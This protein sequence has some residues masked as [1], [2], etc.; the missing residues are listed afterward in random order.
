MTRPPLDPV[1]DLVFLCD[2]LPPEFGAVGQYCLLRARELAAAG[3]SVALYGLSSSQD[4]V[5]EE[6]SGA[7]RIVRLKAPLYDRGSLRQRAWWTLRTGCALLWRARRDIRACSEVMFTG[8]PPFLLHLLAPLNVVLRRTLVYRITD[9]FPEVLVA[10]RGGASWGLRLLQRL[11]LFWRRRVQR[12]EVLGED[13]RKRLLDGGVVPER[14]VLKRDCSPVEIGP[15]TPPLTPPAALGGYKVLLYS[16]NFGVAHDYETFLR[17]Y[18]EHHRRG[19]AALALWLNARGRAADRLEQALGE[20]RVPYCRTQ[21]QPLEHLASLLVTPAAHLITLRTEFW[22]YVLPSK[23]YGCI[24]SGKDIL[25]VG[26]RESDVHLLCSA[27]RGGARY[28]Q[29][30]P[31]DASAVFRALEELAVS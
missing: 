8:S 21:P 5:T 15:A 12:F 20:A 28:R 11:T 27:A 16:G 10:E 1:P 23:V 13:Q 2:W 24:A 19:S 31:G 7:L 6:L 30:E 9:F 4:S 3:R 18:L 25:Y 22:G 26:P 29:V 14:V 17:G